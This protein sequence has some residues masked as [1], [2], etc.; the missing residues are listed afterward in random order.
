MLAT[1]AQ[2]ENLKQVTLFFEQLALIAHTWFHTIDNLANL[3]IKYN[4]AESLF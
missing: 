3:R 2:H 1:Y 4:S